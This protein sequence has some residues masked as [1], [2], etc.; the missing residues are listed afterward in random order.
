VKRVVRATPKN[1]TWFILVVALVSV[2]QTGQSFAQTPRVQVYFDAALTQWQKDCP[3]FV[4]EPIYIVAEGFAEALMQIEYSITYPPAVAWLGDQGLSGSAVGAT[5]TG[6]THY[7]NTPA[8]A[9]GQLVLAQPLVYWECDECWPEFVLNLICPRAHPS[10]GFLRALAADNGLWISVEGSGAIICGTV[11]NSPTHGDFPPVC[12][13]I[14]S[15]PVETTTWGA[16]KEL[17][18]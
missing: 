2:L 7:W 11:V 14:P 3:G 15:V 4:V 16:V 1:L 9:S 12:E 17:Y 10:T 18:Q 8:D 6:I 5:P 13:P